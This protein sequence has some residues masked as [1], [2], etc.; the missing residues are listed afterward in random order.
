[1]NFIGWHG[2]PCSRCLDDPD[3]D[4]PVQS[5]STHGMCP[6]HWLGATERQR[7]DAIFDEGVEESDGLL[8][9]CE[10]IA[11]LPTVEPERRRA[12]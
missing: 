9:L 1:M 8:L 11:S 2:D 4:R 7:R 5:A 3:P 10:L 12:A 6:R